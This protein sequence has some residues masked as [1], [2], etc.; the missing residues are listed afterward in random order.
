MGSCGNA[1]CF[2][3]AAESVAVDWSGQMPILANPSRN[4]V[5]VWRAATTKLSENGSSTWLYM[6]ISFQDY[7]LTMATSTHNTRASS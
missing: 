3:E 2:E 5:L 7:A 6:K 4:T 1:F